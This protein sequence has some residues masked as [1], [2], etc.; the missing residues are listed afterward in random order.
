MNATTLEQTHPTTQTTTGER[1]SA[2]TGG[3]W[4]YGPEL[5]LVMIGLMAVGMVAGV[6]SAATATA[7]LGTATGAV[8]LSTLRA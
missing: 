6:M 4:S 1:E 2:I 5:L 3:A 7:I 8:L